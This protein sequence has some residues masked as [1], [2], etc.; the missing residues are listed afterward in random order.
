MRDLQQIHEEWARHWGR[1]SPVERNKKLASRMKLATL[2]DA[3]GMDMAKQGAKEFLSGA[4]SAREYKDLFI[5]VV[6]M[7]EELHPGLGEEL[8]KEMSMLVPIPEK[9]AQLLSLCE[10]PWVLPIERVIPP[11][12]VLPATTPADRSEMEREEMMDEVEI[13]D[14]GGEEE[15]EDEEEGEEDEGRSYADEQEEDYEGD[16]DLKEFKGWKVLDR[17]RMQ[18]LVAERLSLESEE[19]KMTV[20][21]S[22]EVKDLT[23]VEEDR[24][25]EGLDI[26][27]STHVNSSGTRPARKL[28]SDA[29]KRKKGR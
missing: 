15:Y 21:V 2:G 8:F 29:K 22:A 18:A 26:D 9:R 17:S 11:D 23:G 13:N 28:S 4:I 25:A 16:E 20:Q 12:V 7:G 19:S 24:P 5:G 27:G 10:D 14:N 6:L 1:T 3:Y